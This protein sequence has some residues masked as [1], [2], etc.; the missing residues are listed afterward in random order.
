VI[1]YLLLEHWHGFGWRF[2]LTIALIM[3]IVM[4]VST[5]LARKEEVGFQSDEH[6][7]G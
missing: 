5:T 4:G 7:S 2:A 6:Q 1:K 3:V